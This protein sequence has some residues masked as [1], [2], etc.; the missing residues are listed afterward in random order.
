ME[1]IMEKQGKKERME[2][3][4]RLKRIRTHMGLTQEQFSEKVGMSY[5]AYKMV[6]LGEN[7]LTIE[8]LTKL[9]DNVEVSADF[10]LYGEVKSFDD[11]WFMI[12]NSDDSDKMQI[13][14]RLINYFCYEK[15]PKFMAEDFRL[16]DL[17]KEFSEKQKKS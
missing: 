14:V 17:L 2:R 7:N 5:S 12:E 6:E 4:G 13:L 15:T 16:Q 1:W 11:V 10:I 8:S 3:A 9:K